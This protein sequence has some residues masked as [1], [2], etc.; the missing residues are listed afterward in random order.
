[1]REASAKAG[2]PKRV[3][4]LAANVSGRGKKSS[5]RRNGA[6]KEYHPGLESALF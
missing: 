6:F 2:P 5:V 3:T 4:V 1:M